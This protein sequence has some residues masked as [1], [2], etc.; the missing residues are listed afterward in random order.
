MSKNDIGI[1]E[2]AKNYAA[3]YGLKD[4]SK[5]KNDAGVLAEVHKIFLKKLSEIQ[6]LKKHLADSGT[7]KEPQ[8]WTYYDWKRM[9]PKGLKSLKLNHPEKYAKIPGL[10]E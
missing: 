5:F 8:Q 4:L 6:S 7:E 9:D 10:P 2:A 3:K 1:S